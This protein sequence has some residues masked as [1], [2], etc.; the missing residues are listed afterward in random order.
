MK[1][2]RGLIGVQIKKLVAGFVLLLLLAFSITS[3]SYSEKDN[4]FPDTGD[5]ISDTSTLNF[6]VLSD[7]GFNGSGTQREVAG[8][9]S[10]MARKVKLGF[11]LTCGDN[12]QVAGVKSTS[13]TLWKLN[14]ENVY[15]DSALQVNGTRPWETTIT[16]G[17]LMRRLN[18]QP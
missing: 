13:D 16:S 10:L 11:I 14:Y 5:I 6:F 1:T 4:D 3:C 18:I 15:N 8:E 2:K 7:W 9:M 17:T 12:F